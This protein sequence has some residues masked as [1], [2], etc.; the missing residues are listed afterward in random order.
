MVVTCE[1]VWREISNYIDSDIGPALRT[2]ID[3]HLR[4]CQRCTAVLEGTRNIVQ[5]YGDER[6]F[7][8]PLGFG[9]RLRRRLESNI[10]PTR[11]TF[12]GWAVAA[13]AAVLVLGGFEVG[14]S[15]AFSTPLRSAHAQTAHGI[16]PD[17]PV[18]VADD[19][20]TFHVR[21][22]R[23]IHDTAHLRTIAASEAMHEGYVPCVRCMKKYLRTEAAR[24]DQSADDADVELNG[25]GP[26]QGGV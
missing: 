14:R 6:M 23:F 24:S 20:K 4:G 9:R 16:P 3:E 7:E 10:A 12:L 19:G 18:V 2:A 1:Q 11:R 15:S 8:A 13:A 25:K 21:G 22:C 17:L 5:L 26:W